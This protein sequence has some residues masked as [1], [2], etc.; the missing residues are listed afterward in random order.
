MKTVQKL[1]LIPVGVG[2]LVVLLALILCPATLQASVQPPQPD[3]PAYQ[4]L[5]NPGME[6]YA[7]SYA[8]YYGIHCQVASGWQRF[9]Y[10]SSEPCWMDTRVFA[11]SHLGVGWVE[12]IEGQT[13]Q[14]IVSTEPYTAGLLQQV[15]DLTPGIGYGFH[16]AMLTIFR[17]SAFEP[18]HGTMIKQVG[19]DPTGGLDPRASSVVWSEPDDHDQGPWDIDQRTAVYAQSPT[20]TVFIRVISLYGSGGLPHVNLSFLDSAILARTPT[21]R[22]TSPAV[23]E[24][25]SFTVSWDNAQP[26]PGGGELRSW[27]DVEW[28]DKADGVWRGWFTKTNEVEAVFVGKP[29]HT[30]L[31]RARAWQRYPNGAHLYG[32]WR[33][34]GD[35]S[36]A[37]I[38]SQLT[39]RVLNPQGCPVAGATVAISGTTYCASSGADGHYELNFPPL[40]GPQSVAVSHPAWLSPAPLH[41]LT[42]GPT[43]TVTFDWT[44][45]PPDD[46]VVNGEF[47]LDLEGWSVLAAPGVTPTV[48]TESLHTGHGALALGG[49]A[50]VSLTANL[51]STVG[52]TQTIA[53]TDVWEPALSF[54][55]QAV[56]TDT[57]DVFAVILTLVTQTVSS[58]LPV[59]A[60]ASVASTMIPISAPITG[61]ITPTLT[62]TTTKVF[63]PSLD[64]EGWQHL[65]YQTGPPEAV[66]TGTVTI[67]FRVWNDGD[68]VTTTVYV[69]EV[70]LGATPDAKRRVYVPVV[71]RH[72]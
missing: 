8:Q 16:A 42:V 17:S 29:G 25:A 55:Y 4:L 36:T 57:D 53:L 23:S 40:V 51:S 19:I 2:L 37:V 45:R 64:V 18:V 52:V 60:S 20:M 50:P 14:L 1:A 3:V 10:D 66:L 31:F 39:G 46:A 59:S 69:D 67:E 30:Y 28:M 32:P 11:A 13:S 68:S 34:G 12:R 22:A 41:H 61:T 15:A 58:T 38:G 24:D 44:L 70:S 54:W 48:I 26:A 27:R 5:T 9:W 72:S 21:V 47:E 43:E 63:T 71:L 6:T 56:T 35:T 65:W 33:P 62:V 49:T 7:P